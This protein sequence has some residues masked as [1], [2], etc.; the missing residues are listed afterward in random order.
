MWK[1][2][3]TVL[4]VFLNFTISD[5]CSGMKD[6]RPE[7]TDNTINLEQRPLALG[8]SEQDVEL[9]DLL[10]ELYRRLGLKNLVVHLNTVGDETTRASY[11]TALA[12]HLQPHF[13][14]LSEES[15]IRFTKNILRIL[16]SKDPNDQALLKDAPSILDFLS[17]KAKDHFENVQSLLKACGISYVIDP[18]LVRGLDYYNQTVFEVMSHHLGA[19]N[20]IGGGGRFDGLLATLGGP[21]LPSVGFATGIERLLQTMD[22]EKDRFP[23]GPSSRSLFCSLGRAS[24][25]SLF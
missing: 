4:E 8:V 24:A 25:Y 7:D 2:S 14:Q 15:K 16:D 23:C 21:D 12:A 20:T 6:R 5:P 19:H 1:T 17:E 11:R 18:K 22:Q 3:F 10:C 13:E 9:I